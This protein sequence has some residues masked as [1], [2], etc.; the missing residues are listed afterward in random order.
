MRLTFAFMLAAF[1]LVAQD[2]ANRAWVIRIVPAR[3]DMTPANTTEK[4]RAIGSEHFAYIK[5]A[6]ADGKLTFVGRTEDPKN[7]WGIMVTVPMSESDARALM[8][9]DPGYKGAMFKGEVSPFLVVLQKGA[10]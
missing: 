2:T 5:K 3:A 1:A 6:F 8:E 10:Q 7:L 4:E 9:N